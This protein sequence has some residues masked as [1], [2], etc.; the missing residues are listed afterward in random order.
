MVTSG[1]A[2][3]FQQHGL[4]IAL[5]RAT[6][7]I[8]SSMSVSGASVQWMNMGNMSIVPS[9]TP[10]GISNYIECIAM[11]TPRLPMPNS[12]RAMFTEVSTCF[13]IFPISWATSQILT[14]SIL[15][16]LASLTTSRC[17]FSTPWRCTNGSTCTIQSGYPFLLTTTSHQ[18]SVIWGCFSMEWEGY[19]GNELVLAWS[20]NPVSMRQKPRSAFHNESRNWVHIGIIWIL[21]VCW[22]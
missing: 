7:I 11:P 5:S 22:L 6:Y 4:Q 17:E 19:E 2:N 15:C 13:D 16:R 9:N 21:Y 18:K 1:V 10:G 14:S 3:W 20:C 8:L 12:R